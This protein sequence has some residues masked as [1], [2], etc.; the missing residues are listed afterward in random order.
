[1][2]LTAVIGAVFLWQLDSGSNAVSRHAGVPSPDSEALERTSASHEKADTVEEPLRQETVEGHVWTTIQKVAGVVL[3]ALGNERQFPEFQKCR[4]SD[5]E[6]CRSVRSKAV[7]L[8][9]SMWGFPALSQEFWSDPKRFAD[10]GALRDAE[11]V[12]NSSNDPVAR[13]MALI[14]LD[15]AN[16]HTSRPM[17]WHLGAEIFKKL[18]GMLE[19]EQMLLLR[20]F[21]E[22]PVPDFGAVDAVSSLARAA[23]GSPE[24]RSR[25]LRALSG[26]GA[27]DA[28]NE[29]LAHS[30]VRVLGDDAVLAIAGCGLR[31]SD[32]MKSM[33]SRNPE[34]R[35]VVLR[36]I[37]G[38]SSAEQPKALRAALEAFPAPSML[39]F[40]E[41]D[42]AKYL[43]KRND[44]APNEEWKNVLE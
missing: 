33:A 18:G 30:D 43:L 17:K 4:G 31:C 14:L 16:T 8:A 42:Q 7:H 34:S 44:L 23:A 15:L 26:V 36:A 25:A 9:I 11:S 37:A 1:M 12:L 27:F 40:A 28:V 24:V 3:S 21:S 32:S 29:T 13:S 5:T 6:D 39:T 22:N 38:M 19:V 10:E 41:L 35:M 2:L 20:E